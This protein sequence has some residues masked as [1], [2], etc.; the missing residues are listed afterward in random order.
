[1]KMPVLLLLLGGLAA[2][3]ILLKGRDR[4]SD[5][6]L[7]RIKESAE[8]ALGDVEKRVEDLRERA[9]KVSGE[10]RVKLQDQAHELETRQRELRAQL[11]ELSA[12]AKKLL[13][14]A[15]SRG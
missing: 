7:G 13:D 4:P 15:R 14:R 12:E 3:A 2:V 11:Q 5:G 9:K 6:T 8:D 1:M 10:A